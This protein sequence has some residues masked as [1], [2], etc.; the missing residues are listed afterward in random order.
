MSS[1]PYFGSD[2]FRFVRTYFGEVHMC[3]SRCA[4][5]D[6]HQQIMKAQI[7]ILSMNDLVSSLCV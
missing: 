1:N 3:H 2:N 6:V 7:D 5:V 4:T